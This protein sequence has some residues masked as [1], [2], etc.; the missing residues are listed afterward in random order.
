M[1]LRLKTAAIGLG[2]VTTHRHIP[3]MQASS[4]YEIVGV[5]DRKLKQAEAVAKKIGG[6]EYAQSSNLANVPWLD[7]VDAITIG[8]SPFSHYSLIKEAFSLNKHVLTEK[9]FAMNVEEGEELVSLA[10][11]KKRILGIVHNFQFAPSTQRLLNDI[12]TGVFGA[13]RGI[14]AFQLGNPRRRLPDWYEDLPLGLFYDESP[15]LFY[16]L[17]RLSPAPLKMLKCSVFPSTSGLVTPARIEATFECLQEKSPHRIPVQLQLNFESPI[18]EWHVAV[19]GEN[20]MGDIDVFRD[21]YVRLPNDEQHTTKTV[22]LS[23]LLATWQHWIQHFPCGIKHL[24]GRMHYGNETVFGRFADA[25]QAGTQPQDISGRD[26]LSVLQMQHDVIN[27]H[28]VL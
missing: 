23:S 10:K 20:Y 4:K 21:I 3:V 27:N 9:P 1:S 19:F 17:R 24:L 14:T 18:S 25:V 8:T 13:I 5:I 11:E 28:Q 7:E 26:A 2:W 15:H 22:V 16:L 12:K 6:V